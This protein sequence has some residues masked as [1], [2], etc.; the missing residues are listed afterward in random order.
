MSGNQPSKGASNHAIWVE[1]I[2]SL[3]MINTPGLAPDVTLIGAINC[4]FQDGKLIYKNNYN[5]DDSCV[6]YYVPT[7][8]D[9]TD[10]VDTSTIGTFDTN[11]IS[12]N[13]ICFQTQPKGLLKLLTTVIPILCF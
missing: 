13:L 9:T 8:K 10:I 6:S 1:G 5:K 7:P 3:S 12:L 2:G 11:H 4:V